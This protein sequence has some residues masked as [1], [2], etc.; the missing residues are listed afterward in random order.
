MGVASCRD[1]VEDAMSML[2]DAVETYL[3]GVDEL[4]LR[5]EVC[6]HRSVGRAYSTTFDVALP[7]AS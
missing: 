5:A 6:E 3:A 7:W 4:G 1:S 2:R